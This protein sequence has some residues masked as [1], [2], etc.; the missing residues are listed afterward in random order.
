MMAALPRCTRPSVPSTC[1]CTITSSALVGL[2]ARMRLGLSAID[3]D[4]DALL[5]AAGKLVRI[6]MLHGRREA[7]ALQQVADNADAF[8]M[9]VM[10]AVIV[11]DVADLLGDAQHRIER[12]HGALRHQRHLGET[13]GA[14]VAVGD[15]R[16][17]AA[18][19]PDRAAGDEAAAQ[20][21]HE[22]K[23]S[24]RLT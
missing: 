14:I 21:A 12:T 24:G 9:A 13:D 23:D 17:I 22:R 18:V 8:G 4:A 19:E 3:G 15:L 1:F 5:H 20:H 16:E 7:D 2:S 11:E 6:A 10:Y